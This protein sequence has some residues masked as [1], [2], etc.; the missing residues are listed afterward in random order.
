MLFDRWKNIDPDKLA[1]KFPGKSY[2]YGELYAEI[3]KRSSGLKR[4][5]YLLCH[6]S[7]SENLINFLAVLHKGGK[8]VFAG[9]HSN[10]DLKREYAHVHQLIPLDFVPKREYDL[11][12]PYSPQKSDLFL[13]VLSSGSTGQPK[14][15]WKDYQAWFSAF[16]AQSKVF[17]IQADDT[18][19]CLDAM[20]YSANLNAVIHGL[21]LGASIYL[22][23]LQNASKW[24]ELLKEVSAIFMVPSHYRLLPNRGAY[25][26]IR[27]V[28]SA[29]EKLE[30]KLAEQLL[31]NFP[32]ACITEYY[33]A[34]ELGHISYIQ[35]EEI[36]NL[37]TSVGKPFPGVKISI[38]EEKIW[39]DSPYVSPDYRHQPTVSDLGFID[40]NGYLCLLGREGRMFNRRGLNIFAEEIEQVTL[41]HPKIREAALVSPLPDLL[42][43]YVVPTEPISHHELRN[44]LLSKLSSDKLPNRV[45]FFHELPRSSSGKVDFKVLAKKPIEEDSSK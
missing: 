10:E 22:T 19:L 20:A 8:A 30:V 31:R 2:S 40:P 4:G 5:A 17:Q 39:V 42:V 41:L 14:L 28:V 29:G 9:K 6:H 18:L 15:I 7:E 3:R 37:P 23:P 44:Y 33:G 1:L 27:S 11:E 25:T 32:N 38:K 21:W 35:N 24:A 26:H 43:L 12:E 16:P 36:I 45:Q 13:G 34:A